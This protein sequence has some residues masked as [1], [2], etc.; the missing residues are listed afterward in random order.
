M[1]KNAFIK[2]KKFSIQK[3]LVSAHIWYYFQFIELFIYLSYLL[4]L[5]KR[6][7]GDLPQSF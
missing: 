7:V 1:V 4:F 3:S 5:S 6:Y 2:N